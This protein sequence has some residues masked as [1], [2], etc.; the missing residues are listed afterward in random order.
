MVVTLGNGFE[1]IRKGAFKECTSIEEIVITNNVRAMKGEA[2]RNSTGLRIV[3]LGD[4]L[5]QIGLVGAFQN[6]TSL[7]HILKKIDDT[8]SRGCS[9]LLNVEF[10]P[11]TEKFVSCEAMRDW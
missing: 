1:G 7:Q 6:C 9:N 3:T 5:K 10:C 11:Q 2:F 4:G 8:A